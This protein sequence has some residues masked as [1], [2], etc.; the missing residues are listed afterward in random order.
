[1][2]AYAADQGREAGKPHPADVAAGTPKPRVPPEAD[3]SPTVHRSGSRASLTNGGAG[4]G[5]AAAGGAAARRCLFSGAAGPEKPPAAQG[6]EGLLL[7]KKRHYF[8]IS[9]S[10]RPIYTRHGDL[11]AA[12]GIAATLYGMAALSVNAIGACPAKPLIVR[13]SWIVPLF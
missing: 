11:H 4:D 2:Q 7:T 13:L 10:G 5:G 8:I 1:M 12:A 9:N 6:F 3:S